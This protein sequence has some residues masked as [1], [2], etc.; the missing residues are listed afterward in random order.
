MLFGLLLVPCVL[1]LLISS[2]VLI[3]R[4]RE[5]LKTQEQVLLTHSAQQFAN[6]LSDDLAVHRSQ[7]LQLGRATVAIP[8]RSRGLEARLKEDWVK[9]MFD[10]FAA[11]HQGQL[12]ILTAVDENGNGPIYGTLANGKVREA[13]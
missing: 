8:G 6:N 4:N 13:M 5:T 11:E 7:L 3:N 1:P 10:N 2:T 9:E 12:L